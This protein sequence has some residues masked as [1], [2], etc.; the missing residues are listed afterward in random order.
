MKKKRI[1]APEHFKTMFGENIGIWMAENLYGVCGVYSFLK[2][3]EVIY[4]GK[5][6][7]L[8]QR[9]PSS[10]LWN[11]ITGNKIMYFPTDTMADASILEIL[12][13]AKY[14]PVGNTEYKDG[15]MPTMF[16]TA[17][18]V[19]QDFSSFPEWYD[20]NTKP[21]EKQ[22]NYAREIAKMSKVDLPK[23]FTRRAYTD[24]IKK[25]RGCTYGIL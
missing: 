6:K 20:D 9:I 7:D 23:E 10:F 24:F 15:K 4:I 5:S 13:I 14:Q 11:G 1:S 2:D 12:L 21:T 19:K 16:W 8:F 18:D 25:H 17:I 22:Y 3:D